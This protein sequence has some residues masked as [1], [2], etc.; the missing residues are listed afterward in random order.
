MLQVRQPAYGALVIDGS[1]TLVEALTLRKIEMLRL[2]AT[3]LGNKEIASRLEISEHIIVKFHFASIMK[4]PGGAIGTE[5][6]TL[7]I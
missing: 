1:E 3:G 4:K 2:G 7:G 5:D 6:V